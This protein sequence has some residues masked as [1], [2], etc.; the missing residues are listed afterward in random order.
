MAEV[1]F[2]VDAWMPKCLNRGIINFLGS[3]MRQGR[4]AW[5]TNGRPWKE[6]LD[7]VDGLGRKHEA[8]Q[9]LLRDNA[10]ELCKI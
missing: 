10:R 7:Q 5:G 4:L 2:G 1:W 8:R 3:R 6:S 9:K